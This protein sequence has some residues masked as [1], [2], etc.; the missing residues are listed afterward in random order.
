[1]AIPT[2][3]LPLLALLSL[4]LSQDLP[5]AMNGSVFVYEG[6]EVDF[7][8]PS[9]RQSS[10]PRVVFALN[11]ES[12]S[13]DLYFHLESPKDNSWVGVGIGSQMKNALFLIAYASEN[14]TGVT[15]SGRTSSGETEPSVLN[16][17]VIDKVYDDGLTDANT[18]TGG[19]SGDNDN[20]GSIVVD[21]VCRKCASYGN[22]V[23]SIDFGSSDQPF[24]FALG[25]PLRLESDGLN[26][27][28]MHSIAR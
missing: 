1:M 2:L 20:D 27:G 25:P 18:V 28:M 6:K 23:A 7:G 14:G 12:S 16:D 15:I 17:L 3:L 26:A 19:G 22:G 13:G 9:H 4:A 5:S 11:A 21:A 10:D 8:P 24:I